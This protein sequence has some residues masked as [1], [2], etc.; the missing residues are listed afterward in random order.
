MGRS[1]IPLALQELANPASPEAQVNALRTV[2]NEIVGHDQRKE[3]AVR[4]GVVKPLAAILRTEARKGG[5]RRR[6]ARNGS[7]GGPV[8][9]EVQALQG[10][11]SIEDE[12]RF[13]ATLVVGSLANGES[14]TEKCF[15]TLNWCMLGG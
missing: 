3:L 12:L 9:V 7:N 15:L 10:S 14:A 11:W 1:A 13:Q 8:S 2:K 4:H 5:K 6:G